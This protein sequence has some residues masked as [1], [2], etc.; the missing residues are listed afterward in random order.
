MNRQFNNP[1]L[2]SA[3]SALFS[4]GYFT[5][6]FSFPLY[7]DRLHYGSGFIGFLGIFVGIPF[8]VFA[9]MLLNRKGNDL[10]T[11][12]RFSLIMMVPVSILF[13]FIINY[14]FVILLLCA[15]ILGALFYVSVELG[16]GSTDSEN[17][18]E[19]YSTAWGIPNLVAPILA[20]LVLQFSG[21]VPLF[22][23][24]TGFLAV[25]VAFVPIGGIGTRK[26][27]STR[28]S[29]ISLVLVLPMLFGGLSAGFLFYVIEPYLRIIQVPYLVIGVIGSIP[30]FFTAASFI[31]LS[32]IKS[33]EWHRYS[34]IS[35]LLL[36]APILL[37]AVHSVLVIAI[38]FAVAGIGSA[39]AF[40][41]I[42]SY[43]S[44]SSSSS[45]GVLYYESLF[46]TGFISG[47]ISGGYIFQYF[48]YLS[49]LVI[50]SPALIYVIVIIV[51][52]RV[53]Q[54]G[55]IRAS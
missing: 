35:A 18:A 45:Y 7:A 10:L 11:A 55:I 33:E 2:I 37:F 23:V 44:R 28:R 43:I 8:I 49:A 38:L 5:L 52:M 19:R 16:I 41:K 34:I 17:L 14:I 31:V 47:S 9:F 1:L 24:A 21:F 50:F 15:D 29:G 13:L 53:R 42:L 36:G 27:E 32:R 6:T 3:V 4:M 51:L 48:H 30:A 25:A 40:S 26:P 54:N 12:L 46:G 39:V 20:G 22:L